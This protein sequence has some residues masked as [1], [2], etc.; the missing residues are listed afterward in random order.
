MDLGQIN[1]PNKYAS[2]LQCTHHAASVLSVQWQWQWQ[3]GA[4]RSQQKRVHNCHCRN[5][6]VRENV[7]ATILLHASFLSVHTCSLFI[8]H[9][10]TFTSAAAHLTLQPTSAVTAGCHDDAGQN[11]SDHAQWLPGSRWVEPLCFYDEQQL[12]VAVLSVTPDH[13]CDQRAGAFFQQHVPAGSLAV[14]KTIIACCMHLS[15]R[16]LCAAAPTLTNRYHTTTAAA[17]AAAAG[18]TTLLRYL[19]ENS[20]EKVACIVNDVASI[21]IDAK[22]VRNDRNRSRGETVNTTADLADTIELANGC[23]CECGV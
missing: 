12:Q 1:F 10:S 21:N 22:L 23:A 4:T 19:L 2:Q 15:S 17:A 7:P 8:H 3:L 11:A 20:K 16:L 14:I 18:K 9:T 13:G 6:A 5:E